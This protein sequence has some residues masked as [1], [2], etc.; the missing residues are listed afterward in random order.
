MPQTAPFVFLSHSGADV[1]AA[2][3]LKRRLEN[4]SDAKAAGLKVWFDKD[5][6]RGG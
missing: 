3:T 2:W 5:D 1:E 4:A 6:L